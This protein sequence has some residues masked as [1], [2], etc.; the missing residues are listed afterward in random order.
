[1]TGQTRERILDAAAAVMR[2]QG[3]GNASVKAIAAKA[4]C[5]PALLYKYFADQQALYLGVLTERLGGM[6]IADVPDGDPRDRLVQIVERLMAFYAGSF[7]MSASIFSTPELLRTWRAGLE[8][9]GSAGP[10]YPTRIVA[11]FVRDAFPDADAE[12]VA[13]LLVGAAFHAAFLA[14]FDGLD[15][16]PD[17]GRRA[18][19]LVAAVLP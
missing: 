2:E 19:D 5:S 3:L 1:M 12:A 7:P 13:G 6:S 11:A 4:G 17:S 16:V 14:C 18:R 8:E 9:K 10:G 15:A